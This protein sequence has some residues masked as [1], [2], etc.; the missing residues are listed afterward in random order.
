[1]LPLAGHARPI[2]KLHL[3][4]SSAVSSAQR[5]SRT[6][7]ARSCGPPDLP[8]CIPQH[9]KCA[10]PPCKSLCKP[11]ATLSPVCA[12]RFG[13]SVR[14]AH[15]QPRPRNLG[16][17]PPLA[18]PQCC[19]K[20]QS[21]WCCGNSC[22]HLRLCL[23]PIKYTGPP[24]PLGC[25]CLRT[26]QGMGT[27]NNQQPASRWVCNMGSCLFPGYRTFPHHNTQ[28]AFQ[29]SLGSAWISAVFLNGFLDFG[30]RMGT[31]NNQQPASRWVCNMGSCLF[32]GYR[33]FPHHNTQGA[34]QLSL[35]SAWISAVFLNGFLDF[36]TRMGTT[37]NQ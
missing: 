14:S 13:A 15:L 31:T 5:P 21:L 4:I 30:A 36:G 7:R 18:S 9:V 8:H 33:T 24:G 2:G 23:P 10:V 17:G 12:G 29:L 22:A 26:G 25:A 1:M 19:S 35:G 32:P 11:A 27:T 34:F 28:G 6:E 3:P 20:Q 16:L 37:N